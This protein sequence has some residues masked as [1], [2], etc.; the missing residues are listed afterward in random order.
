MI[1]PVFKRS[2]DSIEVHCILSEKSMLSVRTDSG[3]RSLGA[4]S[5]K[6]I[7][8]LVMN[9]PDESREVFLAAFRE[10]F[11]AIRSPA[12]LGDLFINMSLTF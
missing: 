10:A 1:Y 8:D 2:M 12:I 4:V 3:V 6:N 5:K 9:Y 11:S 7:V